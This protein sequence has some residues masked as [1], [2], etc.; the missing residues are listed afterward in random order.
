MVAKN[1]GNKQSDLDGPD[2]N[3]TRG[4]RKNSGLKSI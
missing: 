3:D 2:R 1:P 4:C